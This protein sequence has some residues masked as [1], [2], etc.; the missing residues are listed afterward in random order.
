[1]KEKQKREGERGEY[2]KCKRDKMERGREREYEQN[3]KVVKEKAARSAS[4]KLS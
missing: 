1:M 2:Q 3:K 4:G